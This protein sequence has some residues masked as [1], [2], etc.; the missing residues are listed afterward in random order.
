MNNA[1]GEISRT[2]LHEGLIKGEMGI[3]RG[4]TTGEERLVR[5]EILPE[6]QGK[7]VPE[8]IDNKITEDPRLGTRKLEE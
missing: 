1:Q 2:Y 5:E 7:I 3:T 4:K 6:N 8:E